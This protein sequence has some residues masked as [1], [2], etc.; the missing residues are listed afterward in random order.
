[1]TVPKYSI[2]DRQ[3]R[4]INQI[5]WIALHTQNQTFIYCNQAE[6][7]VGSYTTEKGLGEEG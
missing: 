5:H 3:V 7:L 6:C 1:M 2:T 4:S